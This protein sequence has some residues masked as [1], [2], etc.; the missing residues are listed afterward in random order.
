ML[1]PDGELVLRAGDKMLLYAK[2]SKEKYI[3]E[4]SF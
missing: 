1:I 2:E 3:E 4:P